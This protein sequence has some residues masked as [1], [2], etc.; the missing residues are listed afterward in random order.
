MGDETEK[1]KKRRQR[2]GRCRTHGAGAESVQPN[3]WA[4][5]PI[6]SVYQPY[7]PALPETVDAF[8]MSAIQHGMAQLCNRPLMEMP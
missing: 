2:L 7:Q 6:E 8:L 3:T 1:V 4:Q 5:A